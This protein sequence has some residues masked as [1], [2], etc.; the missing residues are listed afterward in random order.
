MSGILGSL[1]ANKQEQRQVLYMLSTGF[2]MGVFIA[3]YQ[4]TADSL[5]L[6]RMGE[7]L[8]MA[9][10]I[11]G[12]LG[13]VSTGVFS[14]LQN[15]VRFSVLTTIVTS[16]VLLFTLLVYGLLSFGSEQWQRIVI[17]SMYCAS[18]PMIAL[19]LLSYWGTFGRL[20]N[21]RQSKNIIG[22]IDT[23]QLVAA[24]AASFLI[25][26]TA[27]IVPETVDYLIVCQV[28]VLF[29]GLLL[30]LISLRFSLTK[31]DPREFDEEVRYQTSIRRMFSDKYI[32]QM[33]ALVLISMLVFIFTQYS[34]Q[35]TV[36][37][38][39]TDQRSLTDF[40]AFFTG[41]IY[42]LSLLMQTFVNN[43][44]INNYG[45][46]VSL[47]LLPV[48][49][50]AF[51]FGALISGLTLGFHKD[52]NPTGF[53]YFFLFIAMARLTNWTIRDSLET[54]VLKLFFIPLDNRLRFSLQ[55][56]VEGLVNESSRFIAGLLIFGLAAIPFFEVIHIAV[57][58]VVM[59]LFYILIINKLYQGYRTKIR[60]KLE[61]PVAQQER[62]ERGYVRIIRELENRL[63]SVDS[64]MAVF[65]F[66]FLEKY[67]FSQAS[68]WVNMLMRNPDETVR[69]YAQNKLNELKG[70]SV[71]DRY[72][73][74]MNPE[75]TSA[76]SRTVL[77][78]HEIQQIIEHG[79]EIT[80]L[81]IQQLA[82]SVHAS[83]RQYAAELLL[84]TSAEECISFLCELLQDTD[85][86]VRNTAIKSSIK[87]HNNDV[88]LALIDNLNNP[89]FSNQA[90]NALVLIGAKALPL[91]DA[92]FYR[93]GQ[94]TQLM[95]RIIQAMGR[96]GGQRARDL[97][98][99]KIDYP[100]KVVVSQVLLSLGECGF[101]A[102]LSQVTRIKFVIEND[103]ADIRWN[104]S[105][106]QELGNSRDVQSIIKALREEIQN[107]LEH[108]YMLLA[109]L[110]DTHSI[111]LVKEN[112][113]SGTTE[114]ITYAIELLDVFLSEQLKQ[115]I[116]PVLDE[117]SDEERIK[118]LDIFYPRA[119][120]DQ[121]LVLKFI[122]NRDF[123]QSSRWTKACVLYYIGN[124]KLDEFKLDLL[125]QLFNPDPLIQEVAA[126]ALWKINP[127]EYEKNVIRLGLHKKK[128]L[129]EVVKTE[130]ASYYTK[131]VF[132]GGLPLFKDV[133]SVTLTYIADISKEI[134]LSSGQTL[135]L[136]EPLQPDFFIVVKGELECFKSGN[137]V[138]RFKPGDFVGEMPS[139]PGFG[140]SNLI[141]ANQE[142]VLLQINKDRF[143]ELMT[144]H[145]K[146]ADSM[147]AYA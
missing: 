54:P 102:N 2:F 88:I 52:T 47:Y 35:E 28:S 67:N 140:Q 98:W 85:P 82:R 69:Y 106:I 18:G 121:R 128:E 63:I 103:I 33:S 23:G 108:I 114:G 32:L 66:K 11:A 118:R 39:Y 62:L 65:A 89:L 107:D 51:S 38:Q 50:M 16:I 81:R 71:S 58:L 113:E 147:L 110:Y 80:K 46:R 83:D 74:R 60:L 138:Y 42:G 104:L 21:F 31:N 96:I 92:A 22:W 9:F 126:W 34:F 10:L 91:L 95:L 144:D 122:I 136:D 4:V 57:F 111:Q 45:L 5:F 3:T 76:D 112:I 41:A 61:Q 59:G 127:D 68:N 117:I 101:K 130:K 84:H 36:K 141:R 137:F 24:I 53:V 64:R 49:V 120:L 15:V 75:K 87:K 86:R 123:T 134:T 109:M 100:N 125:A 40:M 90:L 55:T 27:G 78:R 116:I 94:S 146:L 142:T 97:L 20:F 37:E 12:I 14:W 135:V 7:Y 73:I 48:L 99:N 132:M 143:Y 133:P 124:K 30:L 139:V 44:I 72:V 145:I 13:I 29:M 56:K 131:V 77:T 93:S 25:P 8:D 17:F 70:L 1:T 26:L 43:R 119:K 129:D 6:N 105:A 115:R 79:G 19:L